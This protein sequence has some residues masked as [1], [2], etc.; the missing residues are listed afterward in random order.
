M[1]NHL[2]RA[3]RALRVDRA[4]GLLQWRAIVGERHISTIALCPGCCL[5]HRAT[6][7]AVRRWLNLGILLLGA[8]VAP[9][10]QPRTGQ[11]RNHPHRLF[12]SGNPARQSSFVSPR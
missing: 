4:F 3:F 1:L 11:S 7:G 8:L 2:A 6:F 9:P 12:S 5:T 10:Q